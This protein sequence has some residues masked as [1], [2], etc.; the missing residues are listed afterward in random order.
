MRICRAFAPSSLTTTRSY[1][2]WILLSSPIW[3]P[4]SLAAIILRTYGLAGPAASRAEPSQAS[5]PGP[6]RMTEFRRCLPALL[7]P[8]KVVS[9]C[10]VCVRARDERLTR[11][12][13]QHAGLLVDGD[14]PPVLPSLQGGGWPRGTAAGA[15]RPRERFLGE[16][17]L[18]RLSARDPA[19]PTTTGCGLAPPASA[20][21]SD[22]FTNR[23]AAMGRL[24]RS[25]RALSPI[26]GSLGGP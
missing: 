24:I 4:S 3:A 13:R 1:S 8:V 17:R 26:D 19:S 15:P 20:S 18:N 2:W 6:D 25:Y 10:Q 21:H 22:P 11:D 12:A 14:G 16:R 5:G 7:N 23:S 9:G